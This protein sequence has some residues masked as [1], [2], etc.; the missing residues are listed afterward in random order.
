MFVAEYL[1]KNQFTEVDGIQ[2]YI[3][4]E[5]SGTHLQRAKQKNI[6]NR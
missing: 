3:A 1:V 6:M 4:N 2:A 5:N